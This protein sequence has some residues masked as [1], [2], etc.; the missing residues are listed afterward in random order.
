[1]KVINIPGDVGINIR[2]YDNASGVLNHVSSKLGI[3][4]KQGLAMGIGFAGITMGIQAAMSAFQGLKQWLEDSIKKYREFETAMAEVSTM[5]DAQSMKHLPNLEK[6]IVELANVYGKSATDMAS[7]MYQTLSASVDAGDALVFL[8]TATRAAT[9]GLTSTE[10]AVDAITSVMNAYGMTVAEATRISDVM[11]QTVKRGKLRFEDLAS[12]ISMV[13][14]I[15]SQAGI[16]FEEISAAL[17][18]LTRQGI[19]ASKA[20]M[21]LRQLISNIINPA[22][23]AK[24]AA[25]SFGIELDALHFRVVGIEGILAEMEHAAKGNIAVLGQF[26][27]NI[28]ALQAALG[29]TGGASEGFTKDIDLMGDSLGSTQEALAKIV[30]TSAFMVSQVQAMSDEIDRVTGESLQEFDLQ[31]KMIG[32]SLKG[33]VVEVSNFYAGLN[34]IEMAA[35]LAVNALSPLFSILTYISAVQKSGGE[36][37]NQL[38]NSQEKLKTSMEDEWKA[39]NNVVDVF[40]KFGEQFITYGT[41]VEQFDKDMQNIGHTTDEVTIAL[42]ENQEGFNMIQGVLNSTTSKLQDTEATIVLLNSRVNELN[43]SIPEMEANI[44]KLG[45]IKDIEDDMYRAG[46]ALD[47]F[48]YA[49]TYVD[50]SIASMISNLVKYESHLESLQHKQDAFNLASK[51]NSLEILRIQYNASGR[52]GRL[53]RSEK[54][55]IEDLERA[56]QKNRIDQM[57]GDI[58]ATEFKNKYYNTAKQQFEDYVATQQHLLYT[59]NDTRQSEIDSLNDVLDGLRTSRETY[60]TDLKTMYSRELTMAMEHQANLANV[61]GMYKAKGMPVPSAISSGM[62]WT[63]FLPAGKFLSGLLGHETG[64]SS[65]PETGMYKLHQGETVTTRGA[66]NAGGNGRVTVDLSGNLNVNITKTIGAGDDPEA[67]V[68][69]KISDGVRRGL[70]TTDIDTLYG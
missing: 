55:Q 69:K 40:E 68:A 51:K 35:N 16:S 23:E 50:S 39:T 66:T 6:G 36:I 52:R 11:F 29:L 30:D 64:I 46:L 27:P 45:V 37:T 5:L 25:A 63:S 28:R 1:M 65:V 54:K 17:A 8:E 4:N 53:S 43:I 61:A 70:I 3:M 20:T 12:T 67:W 21:S 22:Q 26:I 7:A 19:N 41:A 33:G 59:L 34:N 56:N 2:A 57:T 31:M 10:V 58:E 49:G 18:T 47:G 48:T 44:K 62:D 15:A 38:T 60:L 9:A 24:E 42:A 32:A 14:P 13:A